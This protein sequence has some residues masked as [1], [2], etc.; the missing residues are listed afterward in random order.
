MKKN[1]AMEEKKIALERIWKLFRMADEVKSIDR[2]YSDRYVVLARKLSTKNKVRIPIEF[3]LR[4]CRN[5]NKFLVP[6]DNCRIRIQNHKLVIL[7]F[8]CK[9]L[10]RYSYKNKKSA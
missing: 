6:G 3:K 8:N 7:C 5:C 10:R 1:F 2:S 9:H 4:F